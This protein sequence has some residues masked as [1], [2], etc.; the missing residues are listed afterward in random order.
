MLPSLK[1][2]YLGGS[3]L[4]NFSLFR[5]MLPCMEC[6]HNYDRPEII[7]TMSN[8]G[9]SKFELRSANAWI[10]AHCVGTP[11]WLAVVELV[12]HQ[13]LAFL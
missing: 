6:K 13:R 7:G 1:H 12:N 4:V 11:K 3:R 5:D 10:E 8:W 9:Q 2:L